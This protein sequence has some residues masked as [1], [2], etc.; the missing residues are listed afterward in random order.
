MTI[1]AN[2]QETITKALEML[3]PRPNGEGVCFTMQA[4]SSKS[5]LYDLLSDIVYHNDYVDSDTAYTWLQDSLYLLQDVISDD[6]SEDDIQDAVS[7]AVDAYI[8]IYNV[9]ILNFLTNNYSFVDEI[10]Q[11]MGSSND[12]IKDTQTAYFIGME[13]FTMDVYSELVEFIK[14]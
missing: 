13:R 11:E 2:L 8:P 5:P 12:T 14:E 6:M 9:D 3:E 4:I 1:Q 10:K 7:E